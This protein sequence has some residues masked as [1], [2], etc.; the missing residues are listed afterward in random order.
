MKV[1]GISSYYHDSAAAII[2]DG[3]VL[4]A[5]EEERFSRIKHDNSF[6]VQAIR[7][8]LEQTNTSVKNLSAIAYYEKPLLKLERILESYVRGYPDSFKYFIETVPDAVGEKLKVEKKIRG[9]TGYKGNIYFVPHHTSH[10]AFS[11]LSSPFTNSA[12]LTIDG[13]GE[14]ETTVLW[15]G[16]DGKVVKIKNMA[17]PNSLGLIYSTFTSFLGFKVN[18]DE[19][20]MMGLSAYGRPVYCKEILKM[21]NLAEDGSFMVDETY[22]GYARSSQMW[23]KKFED[24]LGKPRKYGGKITTRDKDVAASIQKVT[25]DIYFRILK[26]LYRLVG[27]ENLCLGG[28]VA[29]NSLANG[30][31]FENTPFKNIFNP[32]ATSDSGCAI[33]CALYIYH[34]NCKNPK[35]RKLGSLRLGNFY[36]SEYV[37]TLLKF[38]NEKYTK[39]ESS[40][41][42]VNTVADL[43]T[44][45]KIVGI[46]EGKMEFGPRALGG[47][48]IIANPKERKMKDRVNLIKRRESFRPFAA[49]VLEEKITDLFEIPTTS[50]DFTFMNFCLKTKKD[51]ENL[52]SAVVHRDKTCRIQTVR[53]SDGFYYEIIKSFYQRTGIP[54]VLNTSF[55]VDGE[56]I[57]ESP[58]Q[59][60]D[61]FHMNPIDYLVVENFLIEKTKR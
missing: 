4:C 22:F 43:V 2:E 53:P 1:L 45:G 60:I 3:K 40:E 52:I 11:F 34:K 50:T 26:H 10:A 47:R 38:K 44:K 23:T 20:K 5:F 33:G 57:V 13:V 16:K 37:E 28:G 55:N 56:P 21:I 27:S 31:I 35:R 32:G 54:C 41:R 59:A 49:S 51:K 14:H 58:A 61:D 15:K 17:F 7:N 48:S 29:L 30:K 6:P 46:F 24:V 36:T 12:I 18:N 19:Y 39:F 25:E 9:E 42:L 8:C